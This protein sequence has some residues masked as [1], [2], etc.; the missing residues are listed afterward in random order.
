MIHSLLQEGKEDRRNYCYE[1][2]GK[3][4]PSNEQSK[5]RQDK[6]GEILTFSKRKK[7][8]RR[9]YCFEITEMK[10]PVNE[11]SKGRQTKFKVKCIILRVTRVQTC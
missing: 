1:I 9:N 11:K 2:T 4:N 10:N 3:G 7:T 8:Y 6:L 5:E